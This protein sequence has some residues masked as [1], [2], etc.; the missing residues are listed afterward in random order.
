[1]VLQGQSNLSLECL[2]GKKI[3]EK[4]DMKFIFLFSFSY[5]YVDI[6]EQKSMVFQKYFTNLDAAFCLVKM[7]CS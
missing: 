4:Y 5:T 7:E 1:M 2:P 6:E 3:Y